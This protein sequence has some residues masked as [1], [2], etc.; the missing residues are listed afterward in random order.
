MLQQPMFLAFDNAQ[1]WI[2]VYRSRIAGDAPQ[3]QS[4]IAT[5]FSN[6]A[7]VAPDDV[8]S[9]RTFP[10]ALAAQLLLCRARMLLGR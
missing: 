3:L 2:S 4:R 8:P 6:A 10:V 5:R 1:H 7:A 9:Y